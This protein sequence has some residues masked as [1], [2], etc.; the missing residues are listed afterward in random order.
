MLWQ[1]GGL[2]FYTKYVDNQVDKTLQ[3]YIEVA[4]SKYNAHSSFIFYF[5]GIVL[6][7]LK[8]GHPI[9]F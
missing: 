2:N 8:I 4:F 7:L 3:K 9:L 5:A 6:H 1:E